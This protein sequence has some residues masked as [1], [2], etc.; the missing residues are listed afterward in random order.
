VTHIEENINVCR[1]LV[2][3]PE[4]SRPLRRPSCRWEDSVKID[5]TEKPE[6]VDWIRLI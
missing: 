2:E 1:I 3:K 5:L 4:R 6:V